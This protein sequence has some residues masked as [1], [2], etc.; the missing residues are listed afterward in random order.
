MAGRNIRT[1][2]KG[3][4]TVELPGGDVRLRLGISEVADADEYLGRALIAAMSA[5]PL[6]F[7]N[8]RVAFYFGMRELNRNVRSVKDAGRILEGANLETISEAIFS[9]LRESGIVPDV[10]EEEEQVEGEG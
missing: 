6:N 5:D 1:N 10:Q 7:N 8:L 9:A 4:V 3:F 2:P